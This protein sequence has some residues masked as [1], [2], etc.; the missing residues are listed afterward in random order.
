MFCKY[1]AWWKTAITLYNKVTEN[2]KITYYRHVLDGCHYSK[3]RLTAADNG[4]LSAV[5]ETVVRIR[6]NSAYMPPRAYADSGA[7]A[8]KTHFTL[9]PGDVVFHGVVSAEMADETGKRPS[10]LLKK[11]DG[12]TVKTCADNSFANPAHYRCGD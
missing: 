2:G 9:A 10:D 7:A 11:H 12:F 8:Q 4:N 5:S 1:P 3:K 6:Q